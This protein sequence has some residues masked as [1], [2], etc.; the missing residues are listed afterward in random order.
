MLAEGPSCLGL[1][2]PRLFPRFLKAHQQVEWLSLRFFCN[3]VISVSEEAR[4]YHISI[5]NSAPKKVVTM[6]NGIDLTPFHEMNREQE[7]LAVRRE[8][9]IAPD[10]TVIST[11]AVLREP[12]GIQYLIRALPAILASFPAV[13]YL[14]V[15]DGA[16]RDELKEEV[17]KSGV[18]EYV[19]FAGMR[20]DIAHVLSAADLFVLPT[21]TEALPTVLAEAMA[22]RL[23]IIA[24][25]VGGVPEMIIDGENGQLVTAGNVQELEQA[26]KRLIADPALR[27]RM[28]EAGWQ[29]V[30]RK[31]NIT[32]QVRQLENLYLDLI[33]AYAK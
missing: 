14:I 26:C 18:V 32:E 20:R 4:Q 2:K 33:K 6:Y 28:G 21:L 22:S 23:P 13:R 5:S 8:L 12:K 17:E 24:S 16:Y 3:R 31:F 11:V 25:A 29:T 15:G 1:G 9:G 27:M 7:R 19:I 10:A 30:N